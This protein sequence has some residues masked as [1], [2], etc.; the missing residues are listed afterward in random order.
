MNNS[1]NMTIENLDGEIW[2]DIE[3]YE[4]YYQVSNLGRVKSLERDV[5]KKDGTIFH[6]DEKL[7]I[8]VHDQRAIKWLNFIKMVPEA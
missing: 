7:K 8:N 6:C 4:G 3:G 5:V 2:K 1:D